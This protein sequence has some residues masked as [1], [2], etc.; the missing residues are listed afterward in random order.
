MQ[1]ISDTLKVISKSFSKSNNPNVLR[2][3]GPIGKTNSKHLTQK[4]EMLLHITRNPEGRKLQ[5]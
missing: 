2:Y 1:C 5:Y 4:R 3:F